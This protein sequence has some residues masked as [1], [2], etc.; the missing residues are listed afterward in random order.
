[1]SRMHRF[2]DIATYSVFV[3]NRQKKLPH[4]HLTPLPSEPPGISA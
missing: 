2:Q 1:V 4:P 3:E